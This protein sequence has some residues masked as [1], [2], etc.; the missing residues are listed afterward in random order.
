MAKGGCFGSGLP[1]IRMGVGY[2]GWQIRKLSLLLGYGHRVNDTETGYQNRNNL[3]GGQA[4]DG[5]DSSP[6]PV[7][8][9][10]ELRHCVIRA[11][12]TQLQSGRV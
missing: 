6:T 3:T 12:A 5:H 2:T 1:A 4:E 10:E 11:E 9:C 7:A 8:H